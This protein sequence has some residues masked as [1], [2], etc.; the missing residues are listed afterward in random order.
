MPGRAP[1]NGEQ[2]LTGKQSRE[3]GKYLRDRWTPSTVWS[4]QEKAALAA[5]INEL[6]A[7]HGQ[8]PLYSTRKLDDWLSNARYR[9]NCKQRAREPESWSLESR[10]QA[11][12]KSRGTQQKQR[13][14]ETAAKLRAV[15]IATALPLVGWAAAPRVQDIRLQFEAAPAG[16]PEAKPLADAG[17]GWP[18][19]TQGRPRKRSE[20][21]AAIR[22]KFER[23]RYGR[24]DMWASHRGY[25]SAPTSRG[26]SGTPS[27]DSAHFF[28]GELGGERA[29]EVSDE[30]VPTFLSVPGLP[31]PPTVDDD[32]DMQSSPQIKPDMSATMPLD[33]DLDLEDSE[34]FGL[35]MLETVTIDDL[36]CPPDFDLDFKTLPVVVGHL[37]QPQQT[38]PAMPRGPEEE[39]EEGDGMH[40]VADGAMS[41]DGGDGSAAGHE[42]SSSNWL[43][44]Y[45]S[46]SAGLLSSTV[47]DNLDSNRGTSSHTYGTYQD[48]ASRGGAGGGGGGQS[49]TD[50]MDSRPLTPRRPE[51]P[52][53][54]ETASA[55]AATAVD[56]DVL[57]APSF[58]DSDLHT[59][60]PAFDEGEVPACLPS[61]SMD[62]CGMETAAAAAA[63]YCGTVQAVQVAQPAGQHSGGYTAAKH[64]AAWPQHTV[65]GTGTSTC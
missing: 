28:E 14:S 22:E 34:D 12:Q 29:V 50:G 64:A 23:Q 6:F 35:E 2:R 53:T 62:E 21:F 33:L 59:L 52:S 49:A 17:F 45:A 60:L 32:S 1:R 46:Q 20:D 43:S 7:A 18:D 9:A 65:S 8:P 24:T 40:V 3:A 5:A 44:D 42:S 38:R 54:A 4:A 61:P 31:L 56:F 41:F 58:L 27:G 63:G 25:S 48:I 39:E 36:A 37:P 11:R 15:P 57:A 30:L 16:P 47:D 10:A 19:A 51:R 26:A 13:R 55:V